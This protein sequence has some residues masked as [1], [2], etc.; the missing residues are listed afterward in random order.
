MVNEPTAANPTE[1]PREQSQQARG[2]ADSGSPT[3]SGAQSVQADAVI[4]THAWAALGVGAGAGP[5]SAIIP[6]L[7][8]TVLDF[9]GCGTVQLQMLMQ[10]CRVYS[11]PFDKQVAKSLVG[12]VV[13]SYIPARLGYGGVGVAL[14]TL[15]VVGPL[16]S[17]A[18]MPGFNYGSTWALGEVFKRHFAAGG[19]LLN[20]NPISMGKQ[21]TAAF[22]SR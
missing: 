5:V 18:V 13:G 21:Y 22:T 20:A 3:D 8:A 17:L 9:A 1:A 15:P 6:I 4:T 19:N 7:P 11:V 10:L 16:V 14:A 12:A 2:R